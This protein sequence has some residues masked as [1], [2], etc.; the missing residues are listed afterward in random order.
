MNEPFDPLEAELAALE[1]RQPSAELKQRIAERIER[2]SAVQQRTTRR[3]LRSS[4]KTVGD[5]PDFAKSA[6]QN[7]TVPF[8]ETV[9]KHPLTAIF[10]VAVAASLLVAI[11]LRRG[12]KTPI[13]DAPDPQHAPL[14]T[15][16]DPLLPTV[17]TYHRAVSAAPADIDALLDKH[18]S[19]RAQ[20]A[21]LELHVSTFPLVSP[22]LQSF[23][24]EL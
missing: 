1:P 11:F 9:L 15:A 6:E 24:G 8:S 5:C 3:V 17:W 4:F 14:A 21:R 10:T 19:A 7:G 20:P 12:D 2:Q 18:A 16:F 22:D 13:V 23:L